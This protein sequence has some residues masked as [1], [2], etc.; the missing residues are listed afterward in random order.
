ML[1][2]YKGDIEYELTYFNGD[3]VR[4]A[5]TS[6]YGVFYFWNVERDDERFNI[7]NFENLI[8]LCGTLVVCLSGKIKVT[9]NTRWG[10]VTFTDTIYCGNVTRTVVINVTGVLSAGTAY[11]VNIPRGSIIS[12]LSDTWITSSCDSE[13]NGVITGLIYDENIFYMVPTQ[14]ITGTSNSQGKTF[15]MSFNFSQMITRGE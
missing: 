2:N 6:G 1:T 4:A 7:T 5:G 12:T 3:I 8:S 9:V 11:T 10:R 15:F 13:N 14:N